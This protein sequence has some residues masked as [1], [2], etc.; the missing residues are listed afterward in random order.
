MIVYIRWKKEVDSVFR[1]IYPKETLEDL[2]LQKEN[3]EGTHFMI[4]SGR[5]TENKV[6]RIT[7]IL[8]KRG[9]LG[10]VDFF[11]WKYP[12]DWKERPEDV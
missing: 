10:A 9:M 1:E 8:E 5:V 12:S 11:L 4:G 3:L 2:G 7:Q 6:N